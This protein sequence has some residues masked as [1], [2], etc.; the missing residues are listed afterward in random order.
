M[1]KDASCALVV[2]NGV[3]CDTFVLA[4]QLSY[5]PEDLAGLCRKYE[6]M[7]SARFRCTIGTKKVLLSQKPGWSE[8]MG[9]PFLKSHRICNY[10]EFSGGSVE[11]PRRREL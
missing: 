9:N 2:S 11:R 3:T 4:V 5:T 6:S 10:A 1:S 8:D 7:D